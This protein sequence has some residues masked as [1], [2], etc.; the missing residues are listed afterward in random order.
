[1]TLYSRGFF[2]ITGGVDRFSPAEEG[3]L[4]CGKKK[5]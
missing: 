5:E 4:R 3:G 2:L 1:M